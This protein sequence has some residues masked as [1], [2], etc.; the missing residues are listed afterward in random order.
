MNAQ[1]RHLPQIQAVLEMD[2]AEALSVKY[3][4]QEVTEAV[5]QQIAFARSEILSGQR[6]TDLVLDPAF[7][8]NI[9]AA[10]LASRKAHLQTVINATGIVIH[11]NLGR[12]R[13]APE[14]LEAIHR[15]GAAYSNLEYDPDTGNRSSRQGHVEDL[16]CRLTGA[17]AALVLNNCAAAVLTSLMC[18]AAGRTVLASRGELVEIGGAFRMP[19]V[20]A[21][22][23]ASLKEIGATNKTRLTDY[24]EAIDDD[25]GVILKSHTSNYRLTGFTAAPAREDLIKLAEAHDLVFLED[26]GSGALIDLSDHGLPDEP[27]VR[28]VIAAGAHAV[29]FSGDKLL[30]GPQAGIIAG[31]KSIVTQIARHPAARAMRIDKLNLAALEVTLRLYLPPHDPKSAIPALEALTTPAKTL[32][33]RAE[34]LKTQLEGAD[35]L[36]VDIVETIAQMGGGTLPGQDIPS[37][38]LSLQ[39]E[40]LTATQIAK[41]LRSGTPAIIGRIQKDSVLLDMRT[42]SEDEAKILGMLIPQRVA[43]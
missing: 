37:Y 29:M 9:E 14:A 3:S 42:L 28:D 22:S 4:L 32:R 18:L 10:V 36:H 43:Q 15:V 23:G 8:E 2:E 11:T 40:R 30:G 33:M 24:A 12:A 7:F 1:L 6:D 17:E 38:A 31:K 19:D 13:L 20:I 21:A 34:Q 35:S 27:V 26:L 41:S 25:T 39:S 5:R 16:I